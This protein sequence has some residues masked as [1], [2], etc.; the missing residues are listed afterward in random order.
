MENDL[1]WTWISCESKMTVFDKVAIF[2]DDIQPSSN[3]N[4]CHRS[5]RTSNDCI[6]WRKRHYERCKW[7]YWIH[8]DWMRG[9]RDI[10]RVCTSCD[11]CCR[12]WRLLL[13][14]N[15]GIILLFC[16]SAAVS[17]NFSSLPR[18]RRSLISDGCWIATRLWLFV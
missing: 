15:A 12:C 13:P 9:L 18:I 7:S 3:A 10:E 11:C 8:D 2:A 16:S 1:A 4:T 17:R 5:L 6:I 14:L